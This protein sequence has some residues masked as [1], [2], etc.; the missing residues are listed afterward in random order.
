M[1]ITKLKKNV[2][3]IMESKARSNLLLPVEE[4]MNNQKEFIRKREI[5]IKKAVEERTQFIDEECEKFLN[6]TSEAIKNRSTTSDCNWVSMG[7][8]FDY[9][10]IDKMGCD[11]YDERLKPKVF[12]HR[13]VCKVTEELE[14]AGYRVEW[15]KFSK[16]SF[17]YPDNITCD[18]FWEEKKPQKAKVIVSPT[19]EP[20]PAPIPLYTLPLAEEIKENGEKKEYKNNNKCLI[21]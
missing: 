6:R 7:W 15:G 12:G 10:T 20:A 17:A 13:F 8:D 19:P 1:L 4:A 18:I 11:F 14:R 2:C 5:K 21:Q 3:K 16:N 9:C